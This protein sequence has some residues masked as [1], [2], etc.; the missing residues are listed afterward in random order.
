MRL[1]N[2]NTTRIRINIPCTKFVIPPKYLLESMRETDSDKKSWVRSQ[3]DDLTST[4]RK[5]ETFAS[6]VLL[7]TPVISD[8]V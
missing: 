2:L 7:N 5:Q 1:Q 8:R 6:V 4:S 3:E